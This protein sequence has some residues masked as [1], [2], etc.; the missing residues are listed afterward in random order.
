MFVLSCI[1]LVFKAFGDRSRLVL[2]AFRPPEPPKTKGTFC[3]PGLSAAKSLE[4]L[5]SS[6][7]RKYFNT[8]KH[9]TYNYTCPFGGRGAFLKFHKKINHSK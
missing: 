9:V 3:W 5:M 7:V 4:F 2:V 8:D 6:G 1:S